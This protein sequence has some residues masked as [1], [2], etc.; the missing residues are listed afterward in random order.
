MN[1]TTLNARTLLIIALFGA[2]A[3]V[4]CN[5]ETSSDQAA[6]S[7]VTEA[8]VAQKVESASTPDDH[9]ALAKYYDERARLAQ[10]EA[11]SEGEARTRYER[12][13]NP[14]DHP[15]GGRAREHYNHMIEGRERGA[16][17]YHAMAEWHREMAE[18]AQREP[19]ANE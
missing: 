2:T 14:V 13:W 6:A 19:A 3:L 10:A 12:R 15:M 9:E 4:G 5:K 7:G 8:N 16:S 17:D 11:A 1:A 18:H